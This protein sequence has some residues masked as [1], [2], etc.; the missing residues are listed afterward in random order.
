MA[1]ADYLLITGLAAGG[2]ALFLP[3][4]AWSARRRRARLAKCGAATDGAARDAAAKGGAAADPLARR[5]EQRIETIEGRL[6]EIGAG[7]SEE[8]LQAMAGSLLTLVRDKNA[9]METALAGLDQL[10][11]RMRTL[12]QM[13][14][15][16]EAR[17]LYEGLVAR[18]DAA[19]AAQAAGDAALQARLAVLEGTDPSAALAGQFAR[20]MEH[21]DAAVAAVLERLGPL[22]ARLEEL[23]RARV[24]PRAESLA[25]PLL[26]RVAALEAA[27]EARDPRALLDAFAA[28][29]DAVQ[30]ANEARFAAL[31][32]PG[33]NPFEEVS[34]RLAQLYAQKDATVETVFAR[35]APLE[36]RLGTIEAGLAAQDPRAALD[37]FAERLEAMQARVAAVEAPGESPFRRSPSS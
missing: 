20:L 30:A 36:A 7:A 12:E 24:E 26:A 11:A 23:R 16:A 35:L 10:R 15:S 6:A 21:K 22:E 1:M 18:L 32:A 28:R 31:E 25:E 34:A 29:L 9:T 8:R 13:G 17:G 3:A 19:Q 4:W 14:D 33:E 37:R 5:L 27:A 2:A